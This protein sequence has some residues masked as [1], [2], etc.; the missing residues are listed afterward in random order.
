MPGASR[1]DWQCRLCHRLIYASQRYGLRHPLRR[2]L[3]HRKRT[4]RRKDVL[5]AERRM[6]RRQ[7]RLQAVTTGQANEAEW[8]A[9]AE[10]AKWV[11]EYFGKPSQASEPVQAIG[12]S[13]GGT[14]DDVRALLE[15]EAE[16]SLATLRGLAEMAKSRRVRVQARRDL[17]RYAHR[18]DS[19]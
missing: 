15:A 8:W 18:A 1:E 17:G 19:R 3:T 6:A 12:P 13:T 14:Q 9:T 7:V 16:R 11:A 10:G 5:R 4:T 2:V